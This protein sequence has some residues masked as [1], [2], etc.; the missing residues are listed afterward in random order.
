MR[1]LRVRE[2]GQRKLR[3]GYSVEEAG[4]CT[5]GERRKE[6]TGY[7]GLLCAVETDVSQWYTQSFLSMGSSGASIR[8]ADIR[9]KLEWYL[10]GNLVQVR[11]QISWYCM[12][13]GSD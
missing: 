9:L 10:D 13:V 11:T 3:R 1:R 8:I 4:R 2:V 7:D 5:V 12:Y 6:G